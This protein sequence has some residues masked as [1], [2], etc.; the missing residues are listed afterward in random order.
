MTR[1]L[2]RFP[3][4][5]GILLLQIV[6]SG[7]QQTPRA[8][9]DLPPLNIGVVGAIQ[10][11][12]TTDLMAG[13]IPEQRVLASP[14]ALAS[15]DTALMDKLRADTKRTYTFISQAEGTDPTAPR[16]P[17]SNTALE[18]W[19][20]VAKQQGVDLLI[21][22]QILD[23]HERQ[24]GAAGVSTSA[25]VNMDFFL[26]D[27][28]DEGQLVT[29]SHY[30]EK[31]VGLSDN[32]MTFGTFIKRGGKWLTAQDLAMEATDKMIREFGL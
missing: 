28:R 31:Q 30:N 22:P 17:G 25:A 27:A 13:F 23:W 7:C 1:M 21:V 26:V 32:L 3:V 24:G 19:V 14:D 4:L 29:R 2:S 9:A 11:M 5:M 6:L 8:V 12:G 20:S 15:F 16:S 10:P 18:H